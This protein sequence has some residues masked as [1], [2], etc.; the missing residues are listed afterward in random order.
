MSHF[1]TPPANDKWMKQ[2]ACRAAGV[3]P[4]TFFPEGNVAGVAEAREIC[5]GCPVARECLLD[6]M[7]SEG[8]KS[9]T[10]R[11]GIYAGMSP[12]QR[13]RLYERLRDRARREQEQEQPVADVA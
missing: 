13:V 2:A 7:A 9:V 11:H 5:K 4:E 1:L 8:G 6:C 12:K 3:D 10:S